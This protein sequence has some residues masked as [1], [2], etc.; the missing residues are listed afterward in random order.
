M[1]GQ[2]DPPDLAEP[3]AL[4]APSCT[5]ASPVAGGK[6]FPYPVA[7][8]AV[9]GGA[10]LSTG[11]GP[12][13]MTI[14]EN[15]GVPPF[16]IDENGILYLISSVA[17]AAGAGQLALYSATL[18]AAMGGYRQGALLT[19]ADRSGFWFNLT[20]GNTSNPD[21]GG[22]GWIDYVPG[23]VDY[24][25][26]NIAAGTTNNWSPT[27]FNASIG[28]LD[29]N[30]N[31]GAAT[32][33]GLNSSGAINGQ[34]ITMSN[35]NATNSLT[36]SKLDAGSAAANQFRAF[37]NF[38]LLPNQSVQLRYSSGVSLWILVP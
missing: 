23:G 16:G 36:L 13:N 25:A 3:F 2:P 38:T 1:A 8:S 19:K 24:M 30:P 33:T 29:V 10:S 9:S 14:I 15:G 20:D 12:L 27:G 22:S 34:T 26:A 7:S 18:S 31:A 11:Y 35:V 4:N 32:L 17:A 6:T 5:Q 37:S 28:F 21:T